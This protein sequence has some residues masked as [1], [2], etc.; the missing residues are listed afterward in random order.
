MQQAIEL[1]MVNLA[2]SIRNSSS[3]VDRVGE[4]IRMHNGTW[5]ILNFFARSI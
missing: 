2:N 4:F 5:E 1:L 3:G